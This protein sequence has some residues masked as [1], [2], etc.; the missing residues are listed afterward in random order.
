MR[1]FTLVCTSLSVMVLSILH[2]AAA[3]PNP[4]LVPWPKS[5]E[6]GKGQMALLNSSRIVTSE[7]KLVPLAGLLSEEIYLITGLRLKAEKARSKAGDIVLELDTK[8]KSEAY[9]LQVADRTVVRGGAY[10]GAAWGTATLLQLLKIDKAKISLPTVVIKDYPDK[11]YRGVMSDVARNWVSPDDLRQR[12]NVCRL[13]K[14]PFMQLHLTDGQAFTFPSKAFPLLGKSASW[15][16][17]SGTDSKR[18]AYTLEELK[19]LVVYAET[20][21]VT[22]IPELDVPGHSGA[23]RGG[24]AVFNRKGVSAVDVLGEECYA[25]IDTILREMTEVFHKSPY[26]HLGGDEVNWGNISKAEGYQEFMDKHKLKNSGDLYIYFMMHVIETTKKLG[27]QALIWEGFHGSGTGSRPD[28]KIPTD[29][30]VMEWSHSF[31]SP[32]NLVKNGYSVINASWIPMYTVKEYGY[33]IPDIYEWTPYTFCGS[34]HKSTLPPDAPVMG[35]QM[36]NWESY[37]DMGMPLLRRRVGAMSASVWNI[38]QDRPYEAFARC[39]EETDARLER[40]IRPVRIAV[41]GLMKPEYQDQ[42]TDSVSVT[43]TTAREG[44]IRYVVDGSVPTAESPIYTA[45]LVLTEENCVGTRRGCDYSKYLA[46]RAALFDASGKRI[47]TTSRKDYFHIVPKIRY[48]LY[49]LRDENPYKEVPVFDKTKMKV[50]REGQMSYYA[51]PPQEKK[52]FAAEIEGTINIPATAEYILRVG[53]KGRG[54][55]LVDGKEYFCGGLRVSWEEVIDKPMQLEKGPHKFTIQYCTGRG[56]S[57]IY[58]RFVRYVDGN[59]QYHQPNDWLIPLP[60][61]AD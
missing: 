53:G 29:T 30:I 47:G 5:V 33:P 59:K 2:S 42:F 55:Y 12:I 16:K 36:C 37:G 18:T 26:I 6:L 24:G 56:S 60:T 38:K 28:L 7:K 52:I 25:A 45:P 44:T 57:E 11:S 20:R 46:V 10:R 4:S 14:V 15:L 21:G 22:L 1:F 61:T 9:S 40:L 51:V 58:L 34:G 50:S 23:L 17:P 27:K 31:N 32:Q 49:D 13:Y 35:A 3:E 43:L 39:L 41:K 54:R 48:T 8:A 19:A